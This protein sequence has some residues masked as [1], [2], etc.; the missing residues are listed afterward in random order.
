MC[1]DGNIGLRIRV[2][3][4]IIL[5]VASVLVC[6]ET[7]GQAVDARGQY[8]RTLRQ[9]DSAFN[10]AR[11]L[12]RARELY[13]EA[14]RMEPGRHYPADQMV[15]IDKQLAQ[16]RTAGMF[17][18]FSRTLL[19]LV[20]LSIV[21]IGAAT[22]LLLI[23]IRRRIHPQ[24]GAELLF[25][26][27]AEPFSFLN[28]LERQFTM[29]EQLRVYEAIGKQGMAVPDFSRWL[30]SKNQSVTTFA[31]RMIRAFHQR[32]AFESLI[33]LLHQPNP[34]ILEEV[35]LTLGSC[36]DPVIYSKLRNRYESETVEIRKLIVRVLTGFPDPENVEFI[37]ILADNGDHTVGFPQGLTTSNT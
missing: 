37:R 29:A 36:G 10:D 7:L 12:G 15:E 34:E 13:E 21:I 33:P 26:D 27:A 6:L 5:Q 16:N 25:L 23:R 2:T 20:G 28:T 11:D 1:S 4:F 14:L 22:I 31:V 18:R 8:N 9:A 32:D 17:T 30:G 35:I 19:L 24:H 3:C